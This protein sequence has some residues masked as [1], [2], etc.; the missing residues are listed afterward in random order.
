MVIVW[1][2]MVI[3]LDYNDYNHPEALV[4]VNKPGNHRKIR[5][6]NGN[7]SRCMIAKLVKNSN[8]TMVGMILTTVVTCSNYMGF[9][10]HQ[11]FHCGALHCI[12]LWSFEAF[13]GN[14]I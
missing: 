9:T 6:F 11:T 13:S 1:D 10:N 14:I 4:M 12:F 8:F 7:Y 5:G 2:L 3:L